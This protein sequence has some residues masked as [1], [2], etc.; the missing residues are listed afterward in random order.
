MNNNN[1]DQANAI[2][3]LTEERATDSNA[4]QIPEISLPKGGGAL[5]GIDEK[6]EVNAA[7]GTADFSISLPITPGRNNFSPS[8]SLSYNSGGGN[9]PYGLGWSIGYPMIQRKTDKRLPRYRDGL[10]EDVFMFSGAEDLVP[11]LENDGSF[12]HE[13]DYPNTNGYTVKRYRPRVEGSFAR[14]EKIYHASHGT[15]W[16]VTTRDNVA[17]IF[18]RSPNARIANP[19]NPSQVFQWMPEFSYDDKGNWIRYQYKQEDHVN[20]PHAVYEKNRFAGFTPHANTYLKNIQYGN[21]RAYYADPELP[22]DPQAPSNQEYFFE[23][24]LD[25]G[26]HDPLN[27]QPQDDGAWDYRPDAFSSYRAGFEIRT[28]RLC[29]RILMFHHFADERQF[30][31]TQEEEDFGENYLVRSLDLGYEPS[32]INESGQSETTYLSSIIQSGYV[33]K[34]DGTYSQKSLPPL[35]FTY[36]RLNWNK[37]IRTVSSENIVNAPVG[38]SNNYQWVDLYGEG[39]SGILTE[40]GEGWYYKSNLGDIQENGAVSFSIANKVIPKPSF[41]GL[42]N[43]A[44]S[45]QDL[46]ADGE[47]QVVF[48]S[49]RIKGYFELTGNKDWEAFRP[50]EYHANVDLRDPNTRLLDLSGDGQPDIVIT[51]EHVFSW[52]AAAGKKGYAPPEHSHKV[53]DEETGPAIVF[54]DAS[55]TIFLADMSGDGLT[56]IVRIRNGEICYWANKGYGKFSA[57]VSMGNSPWFDHPDLF[58]PQYLHLADVSGT[59][60]TDILYLGKNTFKAYI[61]LS[62]NAWSEAHEIEPFFPID[63]NSQL[64]VV[65]LLGT[66][67]SCIVWSSDLPAHAQAPMRYIDLMNSKKPHLLIHYKNNF[68]KETSIEYKSSTHYYLKD[69]REAKPWITRLPF[70]VQVI[71]KLMVEEKVTDVRFTSEYRYHHGYYDHPEREFRGFG[72]VEQIDTEHYAEWSRNNVTHQLESSAELFQKPVLTKTWFH[73]GAFLEREKILTQFRDEYWFEEYNRRFPDAPLSVTEPEL[74]DAQLSDEVKALMGDEFR[75][76]L[77]ACKGMMLRQEVFALD[78][79]EHAT[80][81]ELQLQMKPYSVS[82]HNCHLQVLQPRNQQEFGVFLV[83]ESE[84]IT[85]H[86]ERDETDYRLAHTLNTKIDE[87]GNVLESASVVYGRQQARADADF[88]SL[89][90]TITDFSEDVLDDDGPHQRQ[91]QNAFAHHVEAAKEAQTQTHIIYTQNS[92]TQYHDGSTEGDDIDLPHAYR[93]RL[94]YEIK[95]YELRGFSP[96]DG[97]FQLSELGDA[98]ASATSI[99]YHE[100]PGTGRE[101]RLIEHVKSRYLDDRLNPLPFGRF[102]TLGMPFES[103]QLAYTPELVRDI[104]QRAG[105]E[106]QAGGAEVSSFMES[107]GRFSNIEGD[108]WIRSGITHFKANAG[109][110]MA[111][112]RERFFS[113]LA[114]EDPFGAVTSVV[115]DTETFTGTS[116]NNDGYY[117]FIRSTTDAIDN[118]VQVDVFNYRTMSPDRMIDHNANPSAVLKDELGLVKAVAAEGNGVYADASRTRVNIIQAADNLFGLTEYTEAAETANIALLLNSATYNSTHTEQLRQAG[119]NL[120]QAAS[121]RFVYDFDTYHRTESQPVVAASISRE[122]HVADNPDSRIQL[123][124]EYTDGFGKLAMAKVQAEPGRAYYMEEGRRQERDTGTDLRWIANGRTVLNNKGNPVKQYEPY[125]STNF[126]YEDAPDLVEVGVTPILYYDSIGRLIR[127]EYPDGTL[128][129]VVFDS[130]KQV[131]FDQNDTVRESDWYDNRIHHRIDAELWAQGKDPEKEHQAAQQAAV[132]ADTPA[133]LYLDSLGRPVLSIAH[134]GR[135]AGGRDRCYATFIEL[136]ME[137]NTRAIWDARGNPVMQYKYDML[138]HRLYQ[139]SMDAGEHWMLNNVMGQPVHSWDSKGQ[140][141]STTYDAIQRPIATHLS[142]G[143]DHFLIGQTRYGESAA[144]AIIHNLRGRPYQSYDSA[145]LLSH[146]SVDFKGN[147]LRVQKQFPETQEEEIIDWSEGSATNGL[148]PEVFTQ[149]TAYDALGRMKRLYNWHASPDRVTVY[150]PA[151]NERGLL[152]AE[153]HITAAV[154]TADGYSGGRRITAVSGIQYNEKGQ[155]LRMQL[156]NGTSTRYHYDTETFRL[157]QL[158]T[159]RSSHDGPLPNAP[160]NLSDPHVLQNLYYTYDAVGNITEIEDDAYEPVF[161]HNQRVEPRSRYTYDALSRLIA[162]EGRE[163][164]QANQ[165]PNAIETP[166]SQVRFPVTDQTLRNYRQTYHYDPAGNILRMRHITRGGPRWTRRYAYADNSNRLLHSRTGSDISE[167]VHYRYDA[168][169]N[170]LNYNNAPQEFLPSWDYLNRV[171]HI[172]LGG[173][174]DAFYQYDSQ[175][176]RSRKRIVRRNGS[177]EERLYLGGA[178]LYRRWQ[179]STLVEEIE[180]HHLFVDDQ[181]V[182]LVEEVLQTDSNFLSPGILDRYQYNNHLG[183]VGLELNARGDIISY[184]EYHPYGTVAYQALNREI[185]ATAKRYRYTGMERDGESGLN[186]HSARYYLPWL[187]RWLSADPIGVEGGMNLYGYCNNRVIICNDKNGN[188]FWF[189]VMGAAAVIGV[190]SNPSPVGDVPNTLEARRQRRQETRDAELGTLRTTALAAAAPSALTHIGRGLTANG[191][192]GAARTIATTGATTVAASTAIETADDIDESGV[193]GTALTVVTA[194]AV[195]RAR[196]AS[197]RNRTSSRR[198]VNPRRRT[199]SE[200]QEQTVARSEEIPN[201]PVDPSVE[202]GEPL[203]ASESAPIR[204]TVGGRPVE[205]TGSSTVYHGTDISPEQVLAEGGLGMRETGRNNTDLIEHMLQ[206]PDSAFRGSSATAEIPAEFAGEGGYVYR[207]EGVPG[208]DIN[209]IIGQPGVSTNIGG[210][211]VVPLAESEIAIPRKIPLDKIISWGRVSETPTGRLVVREW[212]SFGRQ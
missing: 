112:V 59:G 146:V 98:L 208:Y 131:S 212:H 99:A 174:G 17:T 92:F 64:S 55:Q 58:N 206:A 39:I 49:G 69:K 114:F 24:V 156:A 36:E 46:A 107:R 105:R 100:S 122:E 26:E 44:V 149:T 198:R 38:L 170:V 5:K 162:A 205:S 52:Y 101:S 113:P 188:F 83:T 16:K 185:Q 12:W 201:E 192:R 91:L 82:T 180:T 81:A 166:P 94:P 191:V 19:E 63:S 172:H 65:D 70:P 196:R 7:N 106:L 155:R 13:K 132:H 80:D 88:Q 102:D 61:N 18:G 4:I 175:L 124:F 173:G 45:I 34:P 164:Q 128:S 43:G 95:A 15:Y 136:D 76:A 202:P 37:T 145:G 193:T 47:K 25:Y 21:R 1:Q 75:E 41:K 62:G 93:L 86:Y 123:G 29:K 130:W 33:R 168:H 140:V 186:Y 138:G 57:K 22:Y 142:R 104:Y 14:I 159:T 133:A 31:G 148:L 126:L 127:T 199:N 143:G 150:E 53:F 200:A 197:S 32:S 8:L 85:V 23:L 125:F 194:A 73:T 203:T 179:G 187:G 111:Q 207:I 210:R 147:V 160:S 118:T 20:V 134:N 182:L 30:V 171:Q 78:A 54:A 177:I 183:S 158:R 181:R 184:E 87:L 189:V 51:E 56:D 169:G 11:Y 66:G 209:T 119:N 79:P 108:L 77:R 167:H 165:V 139:N 195:P 144:E 137:G 103:Y 42:A 27:P 50:F 48:N 9:G 121:V 115:Y 89:S 204:A 117:L 109:E 110:P 176:E 28:H 151:Y 68:G 129:R 190:L 96:V 163:N 161:F 116:R 154:I 90:D 3:A 211:W 157:I 6:F 35:E 153:D 10:E 178:E 152:T 67:T 74:P 84:A 120:L 71:S 40:Q 60:A 135:D 72:M 2:N 141:F 97:L